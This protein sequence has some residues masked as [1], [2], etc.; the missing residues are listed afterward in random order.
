MHALPASTNPNWPRVLAA[1]LLAQI[2]L[3]AGAIAWVA[4]YSHLLAPGQPM[5]AYHAHAQAS[6]PWVSLLLGTPLF[7]LLGA[8][9][10]RHRPCA[11]RASALALAGCY[12]AIDL[13]LLLALAPGGIPWLMVA[14]NYAAKAA[15]AWFGATR[16]VLPAG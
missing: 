13:A 12:L 8:W 11:A 15:A 9:L 16:Q 7:Y 2:V 14:V 1:T 10:A 6:G 4:M 5:A 3:V